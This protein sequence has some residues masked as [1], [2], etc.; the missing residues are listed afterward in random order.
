MAPGSSNAVVEMKKT[1]RNWKAGGDAA[2]PAFRGILLE[3][4]REGWVL[5]VIFLKV[6][7][8]FGLFIVLSSKI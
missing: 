3:R 8:W 1:P 2:F 7:G 6:W 5:T 4:E